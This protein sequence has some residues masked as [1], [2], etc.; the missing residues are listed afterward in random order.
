MRESGSRN[1]AELDTPTPEMLTMFTISSLKEG[2]SEERL[3]VFFLYVGRSVSA[4]DGVTSSLHAGLQ[5][6]PEPNLLQGAH[7]KVQ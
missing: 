6:L 1:D 3:D 4:L 2:W 7:S 5:G